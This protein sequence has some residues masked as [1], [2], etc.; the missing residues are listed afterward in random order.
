MQALRSLKIAYKLPLFVVGFGVLLTAI[1]VT[2]STV[3]FQKSAFNQAEDHFESLIAGRKT[4]LE[5][6][7]RGIN[8]D[9]VTLAATPSTATAIQRLSAAWSNLGEDAANIARTTYIDENPFPVGERHNLDRGKQTIPYNI[10]HSK[11]HPSYRNLLTAKGYYDAFLVSMPGDI[12]YSVYK[13][14]DFGTNLMNGV[15]KDTDLGVLFRAAL[16]A[17]VGEVIFSD[18]AP[19]APSNDAPAAFV[20]A[21]VQSSSGQTVGVLMLQV[22]VDL[23]NAIMNDDKGIGDTVEVFLVGPDMRARSNSRFEGGHT[24]LDQL[25]AS[26]YLTDALEDHGEFTAQTTG[27]RGQSVAAY[28]EHT[29]TFGTNWVIGIEQDRDELLA[30]VVRDRNVLLLASLAGAAA[31]SILGWLF[32]RTITGPLDRICRSMEAVSSGNLDADVAEAERGDEIG[33]IGK[34]LVS[35]Q[36]DLQQARVAEEHRAEL[37]QEQQ[38]VVEH[39]SAGLV[40]LSEGD[41]SQPIEQAFS[42]EHEKLR[43]NYNQT[44]DTLSGTVSQVIDAS[45]SIRNGATEISQASDDLSHRTESQAATL[46]ETAAALDELTASVKSAAEGARNVEATMEAAKQEAETSEEVVQSAVSAMTEIEQSSNQIG[47]II[48][49][50]DDIAFQT[51]L[52]ALNAGV[53]AARAGEA[54]KGFAVVA[55]EVRALAQRSSDAAMEIKTLIDDSSKQVGRGVDLVGKAGEALN[56][57]VGQVGHISKLVSGIAEGAVEQSTGLNE[58][59]TGV[60]QLDQVTQQNAAMVEQA[61]AAGHLL[62]TDST[63]LA[64]LVSGFK[65]KGGSN[66]AQLPTATAKVAP[67]IEEAPSA[68]GGD[69]WDLGEITPAPASVDGS[70]AK[71]MWQDF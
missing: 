23:I 40:R 54:G 52:L 14:D 49:V 3:N 31:M 62:S 18:I 10:H 6:L 1:I 32:A 19:Y 57:I 48:S 71:D 24:V 2:I 64:Q 61:T 38:L 34:T 59:N 15:Y 7:L 70:A 45:G 55:S 42:G 60:T 11:F 29:T 68:H 36:E 46:E 35:M 41:F 17:E 56:S 27:L 53:E 13:E 9:L 63:K 33:K 5:S 28:A 30:P 25:P 22:P 43:Q 65:I 21:K 51:N 12:V 26:A 8:A 50:I 67:A 39:L 37:Q 47:Q 66:V 69:D 4:A 44:I 58:I 16:E 20:A